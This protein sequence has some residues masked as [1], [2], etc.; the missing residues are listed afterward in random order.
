[1]KPTKLASNPFSPTLGTLVVHNPPTS[2]AK[3]GDSSSAECKS[4]KRGRGCF[5]PCSAASL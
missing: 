2:G 3:S 4:R 1:M 5:Q